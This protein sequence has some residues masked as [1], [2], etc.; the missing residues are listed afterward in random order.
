[1]TSAQKLHCRTERLPM[2]ASA[3]KYDHVISLYHYYNFMIII[4]K[5]AES[6]NLFWY[7]EVTGR[8]TF[9][10]QFHKMV[11]HTQTIRRQIDQ[12]TSWQSVFDHFVESAL[13]GLIEKKC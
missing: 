2:T 12:L 13:K 11:K 1:M 8:L 7:E 10:C 5:S 4:I 9:K 6:L 3:L